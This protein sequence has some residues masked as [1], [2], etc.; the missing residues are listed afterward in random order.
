VRARPRGIAGHEQH[1]MDAWRRYGL[2]VALTEVHLGCTREEQMR[3]LVSAWTAAEKAR[4]RGADVRAVTTWALLGSYDWNA[5]VTE[6]RGYYE[7]GSFD[8]RAPL[9]RPTALARVVK[10]LGAGR[11]PQHPV[12]QGEGWWERPDRLVLGPA[13][14]TRPSA[15]KLN[16]PPLLI[17]GSRGTLGSAFRRVC[18]GRG[19]ATHLVSRAEMDICDPQAIDAVIRRV[20]PWAVVNAAGYVRVDAAETDRDACWRDN[21]DGAANLAAACR[22]HRLPIVTFSSDL[23]FDGTAGRPYT[24]DDTPAPLNVYGAAKAEAERR[25]LDISPEALVIRTSAFFG[26]WDNYNF[27]TQALR[28][29]AEGAAF[30]AAADYIVSPTYV[31]DLVNG[32][33]DLVIDGERGI[34]HLANDGAVTWLEFGRM[35]T[36]AAG[37]SEELIEPCSWRDVWQPAVRPPYSALGTVRGRLL[38]PLGDAVQIYAAATAAAVQGDARSVSF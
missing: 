4:A 18:D 25:V 33:L 31:P 23:V 20:Q 32:V 5:L 37:L 24:E 27:A 3:W 15:G 14:R 30:R 36:R 38:Q 29:I 8:V 12:L 1:L 17:V 11:T 28:M 2:P 26:P 16:G 19:I 7:P 21:V 10:D 34:W 9:P 22:R 6:E 13:G 35:V